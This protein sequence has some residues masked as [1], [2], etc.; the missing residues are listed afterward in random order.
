MLINSGHSIDTWCRCAETVA[1]I[2]RYTYHSSI[3]TSPYEAWY[4][5]KFFIAHL[6]VWDCVIYV[7]VSTTTQKSEDCVTSIS[8]GL[9]KSHLLIHW[10]DPNTRQVKHAFAVKF[11]EH[12]MPTSVDDHVSPGSFLLLSDP[13]PILSLPDS[14]INTTDHPSLDSPL[15][16]LHIAIPPKNTLIG[17]TLMTCNYYNL[18]YIRSTTKGSSLATSPPPQIW[19][20]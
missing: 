11:D 18:P 1:D 4:N 15:F 3:A 2:Y 7:K 17:C 19:P 13:T 9:P 16:D 5:T 12:C 20:P 14:D 10:L 8:W 6:H